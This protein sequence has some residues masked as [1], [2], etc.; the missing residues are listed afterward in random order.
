MREKRSYYPAETLGNG[1]IAMDKLPP[2]MRMS[3]VSIGSHSS[4]KALIPDPVSGPGCL[5]IS[6]LSCSFN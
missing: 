2:E 1:A 5:L 6:L 4:R 3:H